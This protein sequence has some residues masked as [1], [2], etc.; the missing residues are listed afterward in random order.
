MYDGDDPL[1]VWDRYVKYVNSKVYSYVLLLN[2][3]GFYFESSHI[4]VFYR[5]IKWTEQT[6]PQGGK[7]SNLATILE[8]TVTRFSEEKRYHEDPRY[9][10]LW[11]KFVRLI[12]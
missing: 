6:F 11:I 3:R 9:V 2:L 8:Q 12:F 7:E 1:D 10:E 5:Y 4:S